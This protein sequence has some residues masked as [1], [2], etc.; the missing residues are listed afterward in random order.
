LDENVRFN[1]SINTQTAVYNELLLYKVSSK[2]TF[3]IYRLHQALTLII[4]K[5]NILRTALI[6]D[7]DKFIQK[8]LPISDDL[9]NF[10]VTTIVNDVHLKQ[11][12]HNEE[13]NRSLFNLEQG[14]VF[15]CHILRRSSDNEDDIIIFNFHHVAVDGSSITIF[16][17]DLRK[18]L[19][20][21]ELFYNDK[22]TITYLDYAQYE[23]L[24]DWSDAQEYWSKVR[25]N[26]NNS[27]NQQNSSLRT[28]KGYTVTF[29]LDHDVITNLNSFISQSNTTFFQAGLAA[30]FVFL[31]KMSNSQQ[32]DLCTG[33]VV[34]N[35]SQYQLENMMGFFAN[36]IP[37]CLKI[38]PYESFAQFC[39]RIRQLWL[40]ILPHAH[41][42]Y[43]EIVKLNPKLGALFLRTLFLV[44]TT[45][46]D[47]EKNIELD[48]GTILN[49]IDRNL[50]TDNIAKFDIVCTL[51]E[52]RQNK[53]VYVSLNASLDVFDELTISTMASRLK[54]VFDQLF[55]ISSIYQF[56]IL[57][58]HETEL[59]HDLND[60]SL[61]YGQIGCIHS[62][63]A[64]QAHLHPQKVALVL[65]NGSMTYG[66]LLYYAQQLANNLITKYAVQPGQIVCQLMERSFEMV[67]GM[68]SIWMSGGVYTPLNLHDPL[69]QI[70]TCIQ[71]TDAH[72]VLV[73]QST[74]D[75][76]H[77][78]HSLINIDQDICSTQI[79]EEIRTNI[80]SVKVTSEH[81]SHIIFTNDFSGSLKAVSK[82]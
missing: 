71:Q 6:Y 20:N 34:A 37:F 1:G 63:F 47:A 16:T 46:D 60:T 38:D 59:I 45:M 31:F 13:T 58:P 15:R 23:K 76:S 25:P 70:S 48:D 62:D 54:K 52:H 56:S 5:H 74:Y 64:Y 19:I 72:L 26:S 79:N 73:H 39:Q 24:E 29:D 44:E 43:Q 10:E 27:I 68:I 81:I 21:Q 28:G 12:L 4:A 2:T 42:P 22:D 11:I 14:R 61:D 8:V 65:E 36:T 51:Y 69:K 75:Q 41:L 57:L 80:D 32:L 3:S 77:S 49:I 55:S 50:L 33:I 35:R 40:D 67:I 66:E 30:F 53:A 82:E 7:R 17:N 78:E 18:A 9:Y